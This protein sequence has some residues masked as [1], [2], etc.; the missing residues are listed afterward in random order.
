[1]F[2]RIQLPAPLSIDNVGESPFVYL[3]IKRFCGQIMVE[4]H[5]GFA[6]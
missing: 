3:E 2:V 6:K 1:M 5:W 4:I